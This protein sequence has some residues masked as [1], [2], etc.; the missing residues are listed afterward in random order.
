VSP[1]GALA[2]EGLIRLVPCTPFGARGT[3]AGLVSS[4]NEAFPGHLPPRDCR[5]LVGALN[6]RGTFLF[7]V[8]P[9]VNSGLPILPRSP[10][11]V[12]HVCGTLA[13]H[14]FTFSFTR[15]ENFFLRLFRP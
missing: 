15:G 13:A 14:F 2:D 6:T 8:K 7:I 4:P 1:T 10:H 3:P 12:I 9:P 5:L 11:F